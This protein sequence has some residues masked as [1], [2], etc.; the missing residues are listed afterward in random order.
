VKVLVLGATGFVGSALVPAL[1]AA[2]ERVR[3][4]SR[5]PPRAGAR[6]D[7]E[8]VQC[9]VHVASSLERAMEGIDCVYYL[10][11]SMAQA[12]HRELRQVE[13]A[14]AANV[15]RVAAASRSCRRIVY[16]GGVEPKARPS[17][18]LASRLDVG[19]ILREGDV[20]AVE[21]RAAMIIGN[22][23]TSWRILRDLALRLPFMVLPRWLESASCPIA[24]EDVVT[25]LLDARDVPLERRSDWFD[26]PGPQVLRAREMLML[27]GELCGRRI[28]AIR[29]PL[30][31]PR[32]SACWLKLVSGAD[33]GVARELVLGLQDDLLP[34]DDRYWSLTGHPPRKTFLEAARSALA[35]EPYPEGIGG[36]LGKKEERLVSSL[37]R[38]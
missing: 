18:H 26:I 27:V 25:A 5:R 31:T 23:S 17:E 14:A 24:I 38:A 13:R 1:V 16:L 32:L 37:G 9:D 12:R 4:A 2:G 10:V 20:P 3:A 7:V 30:L 22:G 33:Y 34:R 8:S 19:A 6:E 29:V 28:P 15:A 35:T 11:H 36:W 21:L